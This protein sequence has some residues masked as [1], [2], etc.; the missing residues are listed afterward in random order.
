MRRFARLLRGRAPA[1]H[2][3][4][5]RR[6]SNT[7]MPP[8]P[9]SLPPSSGLAR[10]AR[11]SIEPCAARQVAAYFEDMLLPIIDATLWGGRAS[12][13]PLA[14]LRARPRVRTTK[15]A[16]CRLDSHI[17]SDGTVS[18]ADLVGNLVITD[19]TVPSATVAENSA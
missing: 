7:M 16:E 9:A 19:L 12:L 5:S 10:E 8:S 18:F 15:S 2:R 13:G 6:R 3:C 1:G 17:A 4:E 11:S 14:F